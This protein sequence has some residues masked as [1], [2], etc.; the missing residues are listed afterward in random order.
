M[1]EWHIPNTGWTADV[2]PEE[3]VSVGA[4]LDVLDQMS[5]WQWETPKLPS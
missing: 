5:E 2:E 3:P 4:L 1:T